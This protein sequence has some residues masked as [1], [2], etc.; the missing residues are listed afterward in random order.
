MF[1]QTYRGQRTI[2]LKRLI[3]ERKNENLK[4]GMR[5]INQ[6]TV[7]LIAKSKIGGGTATLLVG[8]SHRDSSSIKGTRNRWNLSLESSFDKVI[9]QH[10]GNAKGAW[11]LK[12]RG[13]IKIKKIVVTISYRDNDKHRDDYRFTDDYR[14]IDDYRFN[15]YLVTFLGEYHFPQTTDGMTQVIPT[16]RKPL[17]VSKSTV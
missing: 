9:L 14:F 15:G 11:K 2:G 5:E 12:L 8:G 17:L 1:D 13:N 10:F 3:K 7:E 4:I 16:N 6:V